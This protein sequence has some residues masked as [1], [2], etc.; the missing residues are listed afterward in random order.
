MNGSKTLRKMKENPIYLLNNI[1]D[2]NSILSESELN[3]LKKMFN[4]IENFNEISEGIEKN[5]VKNRL[6]KCDII[7]IFNLVEKIS[8]NRDNENHIKHVHSEKVGLARSFFELPEIISR[9][10]FS[11][12]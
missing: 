6:N 7:T 4:S 12:K 10:M 1:E 11:K 8:H 9:R 3:E 5:I 2:V